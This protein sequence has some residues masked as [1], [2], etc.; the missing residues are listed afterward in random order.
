[1]GKTHQTQ[2]DEIFYTGAQ[3]TRLDV[4]L[5]IS[6]GSEQN[7]TDYIYTMSQSTIPRLTTTRNKNTVYFGKNSTYRTL[8]IYSK[9]LELI[10]K[11]LPKTQNPEYINKLA[12]NCKQNGIA[13]IEIK[14]GSKFLRKNGLRATSN[15][16]HKKI[17]NLFMQDIKPMTQDIKQL[18]L[19]DLSNG[20]LGTLM[21]YLAGIDVKSR[22]SVRTYYKHK[23]RLKEIGYDIGNSNL[24][25]L[26]V[27]PKIITLT[28]ST[29]PDFYIFPECQ[30]KLKSV[31]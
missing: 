9:H 5:N 22:L 16:N 27:K 12:I 17:V 14:Y 15:I 10:E 28:A 25:R 1:M 23:K 31:K 4:T 3:I 11:N 18:E 20:E 13:R 30:R 24:I 26:E 7:L 8:K 6:T 21:I 19:D 2:K 29:P